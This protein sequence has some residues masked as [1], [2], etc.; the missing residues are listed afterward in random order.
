MA[1]SAVGNSAAIRVLKFS[2]NSVRVR[3]N[4]FITTGGVPLVAY[5]GG[6]TDLL[7]QGNDY[8]SS[9]S[10]L[11]FQWLNDS[12][13]SVDGATGWRAATGQEIINGTVAGYQADPQALNPGGGGTLGKANLLDSLTTA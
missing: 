9:G 8:W 10:A 7:F 2:G 3:D 5:N 1:A 13:T 6:G 11:Q 4:L 12:F